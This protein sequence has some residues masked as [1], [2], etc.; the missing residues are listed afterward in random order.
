MTHETANCQ[1]PTKYGFTL[2]ELSIVLVIIGLLIGGVLVGQSLVK[3]VKVK[4]IIA[5]YEQH[6]IALEMFKEKFKCL[7]GDCNKGF[8]LNGTAN[9]LI[10]YRYD[11]SGALVGSYD[12][13]HLVF[14]PQLIWFHLYEGGM[15]K[16][17]Y[18]FN[19]FSL[20]PNNRLQPGINSPQVKALDDITDIAGL[21]FFAHKRPGHIDDANWILFEIGAKDG[22]THEGLRGRAFNPETALAIDKKIDDAIHWTGKIEVDGGYGGCTGALGYDPNATDGCALFFYHKFGDMPF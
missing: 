13:S 20:A 9:G 15:T 18:T 8:S 16:T 6:I 2:V 19:F 1:L 7:P 10:G 5:Y 3:S 11:I 21:G 22:S 4:N 17:L 12:D 14:E